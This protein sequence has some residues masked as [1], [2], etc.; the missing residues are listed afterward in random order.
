MKST[1]NGFVVAGT[2]A[3]GALL[4]SLG[5][6]ASAQA[7]DDGAAAPS[8]YPA[9]TYAP[10]STPS[11]AMR[12]L[13]PAP[14]TV[15]VGG[16]S[17][18]ARSPS[19]TSYTPARGLSFPSRASYPGSAAPGDAGAMTFPSRMGDPSLTRT[20]DVGAS[21]LPS[22]T[23]YAGP[24]GSPAAM[25]GRPMPGQEPSLGARA[26]MTNPPYSV[27]PT[28]P[29][30]VSLLRRFVGLLDPSEVND[31]ESKQ[32]ERDPNTGFLPLST[33]PWMKPSQSH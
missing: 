16:V 5:Q 33:K 10:A 8:T 25:A 1:S 27:P 2:L 17:I 20:T 6:K 14:P 7:V 30:R 13:Y 18:N 31:S 15:R 9:A 32:V 24:T 4:G 21:G 11:A 3:L 26:G 22:A 12:T 23:P 19:P 28:K 29:R